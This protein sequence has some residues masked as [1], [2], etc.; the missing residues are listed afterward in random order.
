MKNKTVLFFCDSQGDA[1]IRKFAGICAFGRRQHWSVRFIYGATPFRDA[2]ATWK[3]DGVITDSAAFASRRAT[4]IPTVFIDAKNADKPRI[5]P[6][7]YHDPRP[8]AQLAAAEFARLGLEHLAYLP[9]AEESVWSDERQD[10]FKKAASAARLPVSVFK[11][12]RRRENVTAD[13]L[14]RL[15]DWAQS[16][17]KPCG[18]FAAND[19]AA[20]V[21]LAVCPRAGV[22]VPQ[23]LAVI[24][25]DDSAR[26]CENTLPPLTS[27]SPAFKNSGEMAAQLLDALMSG[28]KPSAQTLR[29]GAIGLVRRDSTK[30]V[31][32]CATDLR[33]S[34]D[35]IYR[36][37]CQG[38]RAR[39]VLA[40][41]KVSRRSAEMQFKAAT[42][43]TVLD[44]INNVRL[45]HAK[46]LLQTTRLTLAEIASQCGYKS[47]SHLRKI[48]ERRMKMPMGAWRRAHRK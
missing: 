24:G 35:L 25:V 43:R 20:D 34:R 28:E 7:V 9:P 48:F 31:Y 47:S 5:W 1:A 11:K 19:E 12:R 13:Y 21:L 14:R 29:F 6:G 30:H 22:R 2:L 26:I 27:V 45:R 42:G 15:Q 40:H 23:D 3:P 8:A 38:L 46:K 37:A 16:L 17:P 4:D 41:L 18:V 44:E 36:E 33:T 39:D 32:Q 10:E